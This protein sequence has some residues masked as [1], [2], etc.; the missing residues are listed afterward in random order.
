MGL[1]FRAAAAAAAAAMLAG[2]AAPIMDRNGK[3]LDTNRGYVMQDEVPDVGAKPSKEEM[4]AKLEAEGKQGVYVRD[5]RP[6]A[7]P[8][9]NI[10]GG[11]GRVESGWLVCYSHRVTN[12]ITRE[13]KVLDDGLLLKTAAGGGRSSLVG[14]GVSSSCQSAEARMRKLGVLPAGK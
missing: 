12:L 3:P 14:P 13:E 7:M 9:R 5:I 8:L 11:N 6:I 2:C 4:T 1:Y 10:F